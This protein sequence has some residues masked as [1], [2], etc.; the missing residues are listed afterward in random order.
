MTFSIEQ[1]TT[2]V[3][4]FET[5]SFSKA[6]TQLGKHRTTTSQV[7]GNLE[8]DLAIPLFERVGRSVEAT[9]AGKMLYHYAKLVVEQASALNKVAMSLSSGHL[10]EISIAYT[11]FVP[12]NVLVA[13]RDALAEEYP[14]L[15]VN[16][17]IRAREEIR[18]GIENGSFHIGFVNVDARRVITNMDATFLRN[19]SFSIYCSKYSDLADTSAD[20]IFA[21]LKTTRQLVLK[22]LIEDDMAQK[23]ILSANYDLV[24]SMALM[25][26]LVK[27]DIGWGI[28]PRV[29]VNESSIDGLKELKFDEFKDDIVVPIAMWCTY[30]NEITDIKE[31]IQTAIAEFVKMYQ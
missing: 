30:S 29:S 20:L 9:D 25:V 26:K 10:Q 2:F 18:E 19:I 31:S 14:L 6:A 1:L 12:N 16:F 28:L 24:D 7:I 27:E 8:D 3:A 4:V 22:S 21:K 5:K 15:K 13:V 11:S 23:I 17:F